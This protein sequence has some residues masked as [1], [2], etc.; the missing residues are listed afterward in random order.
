MTDFLAGLEV[1]LADSFSI[2][3]NALGEDFE[4][5]PF[6]KD[7]LTEQDVTEAMAELAGS[8]LRQFQGK[9][10]ERGALN[11]FRLSPGTLHGRGSHRCPCA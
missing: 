10:R 5:V 9:L 3:P 8:D 6:A 7:R 11:A 4:V 1:R 2:A